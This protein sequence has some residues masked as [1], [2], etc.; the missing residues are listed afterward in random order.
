MRA[1]NNG[2]CELTR[3]VAVSRTTDYEIA[4]F[5]II[6]LYWR[7][8]LEVPIVRLDP[9]D[10]LYPRHCRGH[11]S[12]QPRRALVRAGRARQRRCRRSRQPRDSG[13]GEVA[14]DEQ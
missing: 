6:P 3:Y 7:V 1:L 12:G 8:L 11:N 2:A 9:A 13:A 4:V 10:R 14:A 5:V